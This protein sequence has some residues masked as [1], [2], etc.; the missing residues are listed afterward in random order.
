MTRDERFPP[1]CRLRHQRD[2]DRVFHARCSVGQDDLVVYAA[3][4][5]TDTSRLGLSVSRRVGNAV[6]RN[7]WKRWLR[8][9]F[10]RQ[11][12]E[13]PAG[14][15][16]VI[17]VRARSKPRGATPAGPSTAEVTFAGVHQLLAQLCWRAARR[18]ERRR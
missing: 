11:R 6:R 1:S 3:A 18:W 17:V 7:K 8:E 16:F 10:R 4:N 14:F 2:F 15:D 9:A 5:Q 12:P 13:L